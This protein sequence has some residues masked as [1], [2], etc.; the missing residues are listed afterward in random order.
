MGG[1]GTVS[2]RQGSG[3]SD[4]GSWYRVFHRGSSLIL[5]AK[6]VTIGMVKKVAH[7]KSHTISMG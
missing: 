2:G 1:S 7:H 5:L 3:G 4:G 6:V